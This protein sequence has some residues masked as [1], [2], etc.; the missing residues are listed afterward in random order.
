MDPW[1]NPH[2]VARVD[3]PRPHERTVTAQAVSRYL[4]RIVGI[5][6]VVRGTR[7]GITVSRSWNGVSVSADYDRRTEARAVL[8]AVAEGLTA[9]YVVDRQSDTSLFVSR[10]K[11]V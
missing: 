9:R 8:D 2:D 7:E 10:R 6:S 4:A 5:R 11:D 3:G 1:K